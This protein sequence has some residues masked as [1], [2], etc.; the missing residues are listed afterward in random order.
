MPKFNTNWPIDGILTDETRSK[1]Q[2]AYRH[3][4]STS[5]PGIEETELT[6]GLP[7]DVDAFLLSRFEDNFVHAEVHIVCKDHPEL[8]VD[9][10]EDCPYH[11]DGD[12][13]STLA[14]LGE[15]YADLEQDLLEVSALMCNLPEFEEELQQYVVDRVA[16]QSLTCYEG[17]LTFSFGFWVADVIVQSYQD[18]EHEL[19]ERVGIPIEPSVEELVDAREVE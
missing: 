3:N 11:V 14:D 4:L 16:F 15:E 12:R 10:V 2:S 5:G 19:G 9:V 18:F 8:V 1:I 13:L 6:D 7:L 17:L